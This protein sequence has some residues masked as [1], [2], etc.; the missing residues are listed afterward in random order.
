MGALFSKPKAPEIKPPAPALEKPELEPVKPEMGADD[1]ARKKTKG[2][3]GLRVEY[4]GSGKGT[5]IA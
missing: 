3:K 5:N 1:S 4:V 2:K